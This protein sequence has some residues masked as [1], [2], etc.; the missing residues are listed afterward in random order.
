MIGDK[1][2]QK[3]KDAAIAAAQAAL[4]KRFG[5]E[6]VLIKMSESNATYE[7]RSTGRNDLDTKSGGGFPNGKIIEVY[8]EEATGKTGFVL[9][10]V[11]V[12]Q[13]LGGVVGYID[14]EHALDT[15]Y[16]QQIGVNIDDL[17][18]SQPTTA[19]EAF[20]TIRT[21]INTRVV[22]LIVVDSVS[23]LVPLTILEGE[24]GEA[25]MAALGRIMS[26]G[27]TQIIGIASDIGC[28]VVF[29][30]QLRDKINSYG[31]GKVP[32]GGN[33]L[34]F[35]S[36]QRYEVKK[37]GQIKEGEEVVGFKQEIKIV[38]NK[39]VPPFK[40]A[41]FNITYGIGADNFQGFVDALVYEGIFVKKGAWF[42]YDGTNI[43]QG[44]KKLRDVLADNPELKEVL[45][46]ALENKLKEKK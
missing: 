35:Y 26:Q 8:G 31:G 21:L 33:A 45:E 24:T 44:V 9:D 6:P 2:S 13:D 27:L 41:A 39:V 25:K 10:H 36:S 22:D 23:A 11:K 46:E 38:K 14:S 12:V 30:N 20:A 28:T 16:C 42:A 34:K 29:I 43:A 4:Q 18:F 3:N 32:S 37:V 5:G 1:T 7:C 17:L 40:T 19:E 15:G